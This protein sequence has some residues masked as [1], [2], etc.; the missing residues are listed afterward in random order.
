MQTLT[1]DSFIQ[2]YTDLDY[3]PKMVNW[4]TDSPLTF[5]D[6]QITATVLQRKREEGDDWEFIPSLKVSSATLSASDDMY[7]EDPYSEDADVLLEPE[8]DFDDAIRSIV[9][10]ANAIVRKYM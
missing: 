4:T 1:Q 7:G 9:A 3:F 8:R 2:G 6:L 10:E 5:G